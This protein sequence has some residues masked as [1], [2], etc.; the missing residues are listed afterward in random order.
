M[1]YR[2]MEVVAPKRPEW[3]LAREVRE[4]WAEGPKVRMVMLAGVLI[5]YGVL[6]TT[7]LCLVSGSRNIPPSEEQVA[8]I[9]THVR[10]RECV[11]RR[12]TWHEGPMKW[13]SYET[14]RNR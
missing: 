2:T 13:C 10:Y 6:Y 14:W 3:W 5:A 12:G 9:S 1:P 7:V 11:T 8:L 4:G